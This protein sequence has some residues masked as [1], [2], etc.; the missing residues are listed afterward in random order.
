MTPSISDL[1]LDP[2]Q[3]PDISF[4]I[5]SSMDDLPKIQTSNHFDNNYSLDCCRDFFVAIIERTLSYFL[6]YNYSLDEINNFEQEIKTLLISTEGDYLMDTYNGKYFTKLPDYYQ[7]TYTVIFSKKDELLTFAVQEYGDCFLQ[8]AILLITNE[9]IG[10]IDSKT[11][12]EIV[13]I[14]YSNMHEELRARY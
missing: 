13:D 14:L 4:M 11:A 12:I 9:L 10:K 6:K 5:S 1:E 7:N 2:I 8:W 3:H